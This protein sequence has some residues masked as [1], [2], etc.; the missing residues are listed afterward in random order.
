MSVGPAPDHAVWSYDL[1]MVISASNRLL[2]SRRCVY[3]SA[4]YLDAIASV[5]L[6]MSVCG[7]FLAAKEQL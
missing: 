1:Q 3:G 5:G 6:H 7:I 4:L 2:L